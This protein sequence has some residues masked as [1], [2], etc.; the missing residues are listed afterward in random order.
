M[1]LEQKKPPAPAK[2]RSCT[3]AMLMWFIVGF[4][5]YMA[6]FRAFTSGAIGIWGV[7]GGLIL[8]FWITAPIGVKLRQWSSPTPDIEAFD[9]ESEDAPK[10]FAA[11][12][13]RAEQPMRDIG[14]RLAGCLRITNSG[15]VPVRSSRDSKTPKKG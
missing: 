15:P 1:S 6:A 10:E 9:V 5:A 2:P 13:R 14:F 12:Y 7:L 11:A 4:A 8:L 3:L